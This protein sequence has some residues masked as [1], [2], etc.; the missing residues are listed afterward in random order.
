MKHMLLAALFVVSGTVFAK[1][2]CDCPTC[3]TVECRDTFSDASRDKNSAK[4]NPQVSSSKKGAKKAK[5]KDQ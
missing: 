5:I 2:N 3:K 4:K 1:G